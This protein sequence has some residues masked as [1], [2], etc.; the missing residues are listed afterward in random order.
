MLF[1]SWIQP[2]AAATPANPSRVRASR[3]GYYLLSHRGQ[4]SLIGEVIAGTDQN[5]TSAAGPPRFKT[6]KL[7]WFV[8]GDYQADRMLNFRARFDRLEG[9]RVGAT[10]VREQ[11]S[12]N[13]YALEGE[14]V[15]VPFCEIRWT[16][17]LIDPVAEKTAV[18][19]VVDRDT[20]KQGY[21]QFHFSY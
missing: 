1:R 9:N 6:N 21:I 4:A 3:W 14:V 10:A 18:L 20:E 11:S 8:E 7:A 5:A 13:R 15:P 2:L 16:L 12:Y 17:R 19:P